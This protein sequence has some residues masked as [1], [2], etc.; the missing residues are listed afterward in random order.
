MEGFNDEQRTRLLQF[1]TGT[2][3][4]PAG[5]FRELQGV[6][7]VPKLF[8]IAGNRGTKKGL[9]QRRSCFS[10]RDWSEARI[11]IARYLASSYPPSLFHCA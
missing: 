5:G 8:N 6:D 2:S 7:G 4:L 11:D 10:R 3:R 1:V 9:L